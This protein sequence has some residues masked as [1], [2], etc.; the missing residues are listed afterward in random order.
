MNAPSTDKARIILSSPKVS[1]KTLRGDR[2]SLSSGKE[3]RVHKSSQRGPLR[4][5]KR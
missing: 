3:V 1:T 2:V 5:R 4:I